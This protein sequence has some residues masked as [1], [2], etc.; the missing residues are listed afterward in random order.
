MTT[1]SV[2]DLTLHGE[3]NWE[4]PI[5]KVLRRETASPRFKIF[6]MK[7]GMLNLLFYQF[8]D[9]LAMKLRGGGTLDDLMRKQ[10]RLL[11]E[12]GV[13]TEANEKMKALFEEHASPYEDLEE[14]D[15]KYGDAWCG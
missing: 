2:E 11:V 6:M 1:R 8:T 12:E 7:K 14:A 13:V 10:R 4:D 3:Y 5:Y 9:M 15:Y